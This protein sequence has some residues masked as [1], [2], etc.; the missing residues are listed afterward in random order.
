MMILQIIQASIFVSRRQDEMDLS[1]Y[2]PSEL[3]P[4]E[5]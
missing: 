4:D 1:R 5:K 3:V 2:R